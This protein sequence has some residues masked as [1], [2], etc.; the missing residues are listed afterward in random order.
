MLLDEAVQLLNDDELFNRCRKI[1]NL[2]HR[3]RPCHAQLEHR[4]LV[5]ADLLDI[6]VAGRRGD[7]AHRLVRAVLD[8]VD[9]SGLRP[10]GQVGGALLNDRVAAFGVA[11]HHNVL[12]AVLLIGLD[13]GLRAL[14]RLYH[15]LRVRYARAH[16]EQ[17]GRVVFLGQLE[18]QF[19]ERERFRRVSRL[20]HGHL[21][22]LGVVAGVLLILGRVHARVIGHADNHAAVHAR[23][24]QGKQRVGRNVQADVLHAA[25]AAAAGK[26]RTE[27][28]FGRYLFIGRPLGIDFRVFC[29]GLRDLGTRRTGIAGDKA[30]SGLIQAAGN[31]FIAQHQRFHVVI[32]PVQCVHA[33]RRGK[34]PRLVPQGCQKSVLRPSAAGPA[35]GTGL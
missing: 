34:K 25:E 20:E 8:A 4:V 10:C 18:G 30:A 17:H 24:G 35:G 28:R 19:G 5:A 9:L 2:L 3:H 11:R 15:T 12:G 32:P 1:A 21:G 6:L 29:G 7:D 14:T 23:V 22:R 13:R 27:R 16:L 33:I 31:G 26:R